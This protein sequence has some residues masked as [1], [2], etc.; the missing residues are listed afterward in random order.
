MSSYTS[1]TAILGEIQLSDLIALTDDAPKQG[2]VNTTV[3]N[4]II[5]NA[6]GYI[7][8]KCANLYGEQLPFTPAPNSPSSVASYTALTIACYRLFRRR[9]V[10]DEKNK[11]FDDWKDVK[12]F[13]DGVNK[14]DNHLDDV[15]YRDFPQVVHTGQSSLYGGQGSNYTANSM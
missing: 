1:Q 6:S 8:S 15:P 3:L 14:G 4:Q 2:I 11:F 9:E 5:T 7:D 12:E 13:L 10:P